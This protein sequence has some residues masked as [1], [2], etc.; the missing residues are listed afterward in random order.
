MLNINRIFNS[1]TRRVS[2]I[3]VSTL[4]Q[5]NVIN[6]WIF[7]EYYYHLKEEIAIF[8]AVHMIIIKMFK[9]WIDE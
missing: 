2:Y 1:S 7:S 3:L 5:I 6:Y 9:I 8:G 4:V